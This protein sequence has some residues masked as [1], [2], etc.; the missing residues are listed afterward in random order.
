MKPLH[1]WILVRLEPLPEKIG[2]LFTL[3]G[4]RVRTAVVLDVGPGVHKPGS[5]TRVPVGVDKGERV[6]FFREHLEHK[7]GKQLVSA[8]KEVGD[9]LGLIRATDVL[10]VIAA[11]SDV[12]VSA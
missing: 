8:L 9:D 10:F 6:A 4:D 7:Q 12:R 11:G 1:D 3:H 5:N 2:S